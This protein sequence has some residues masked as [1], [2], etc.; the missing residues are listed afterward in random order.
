MTTLELLEQ[1]ARGAT[2]PPPGS[3]DRER[4]AAAR[5]VIDD[6]L[7]QATP[8]YGVTTG[9]GRLA[10]VQIPAADAAELQV[11]LVRSHAVGAGPPLSRDVVR[12]MLL[13]L[14]ASLR[15]GHSGVR[16]EV[17][18]L[19]QALLERDVVP[20]IPSKGSVGSSG[21]L[22][23]LAHLALVLI[24]EGEATAGGER[25]PGGEALSRAGLEPLALSAKEG[26]ALINGTHLM[27]AAGGLAVRESAR[28]IDAATVATALS[29]EAFK[30]STVPFDARLHA[31]RPQPGQ[32]AVAE[33]LRT[34]L[35]GS[36]VV[37]SH[38]DCGRVQDPYTLRCAPQVLG[39]VSDAVAYVRG[40]IERELHAVTDNPL[41]FPGDGD[42]LSGGNFHGQPLSLDRKSTRLNSSHT[43]ISYA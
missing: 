37:E 12:G 33:R 2:P 1:V 26:L 8:V 14:G 36:P 21:D 13:L 24:G 40:A 6:A 39:A 43:V 7:A 28:L 17:V 19:L 5:A 34:L 42:V 25:L 18:E 10:S 15:R 35:A 31:L 32:Q 16:P 4:I 41:V 27:A 38:A 3:G 23:P 30:G 20:V 29:L 11:N 22:A 9:F